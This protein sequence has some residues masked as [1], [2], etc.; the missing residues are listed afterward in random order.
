MFDEIGSNFFETLPT[1][2]DMLHDSHSTIFLDSGRSAIR[3]ALRSI[4]QQQKRAVLP[5]YT[6]ETVI[7]PFIELGY[8]ISYY[9][10]DR[11][12]LVDA[13]SFRIL[14]ERVQ[15]TVILVHPYFGFDTIHNIRGYLAKKH[16]AGIVIIEDLTH[17]LFLERHTSCVDFYVGSLRKWSGIPDGGF[18]AVRNDKYRIDPPTRENTEYVSIR[19]EAQNLKRQ[20]V[21]A[22]DDGTKQ[23]YRTL[24]ATSEALLDKQ[25]QIYTMS[26]ISRCA[27]VGTDYDQLKKRR[28]E[29]YN[30]LLNGL[31]G[32]V[33][34]HIPEALSGK[35]DAPLYFPIFAAKREILQRYMAERHI[36]LPVIWPMPAQVRGKL[37]TD[38][39]YIYSRVLAIP[40]DQRYE[41][42]D[43]S[44]VVTGIHEFFL[45]ELR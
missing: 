6:C 18:L 22:M 27:I 20:Y 25:A 29:N 28:S 15:P 9:Q 38:T 3:L 11:D 34:I 14:V 13:N 33:E 39:D 36:Y 12:L 37:S 24:F 19:C 4:H 32:S 10:V 42:S 41:N 45:E 43:M 44:R 21:L 35:S 23:R 8:D 2:N 7:L 1:P 31:S 40:C 26:H 5:A 30:F 16:D 17:G